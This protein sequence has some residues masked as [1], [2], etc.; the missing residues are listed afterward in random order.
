VRGARRTKMTM[1]NGA[2]YLQTITLP[3]N[4][5]ALWQVTYELVNQQNEA[6][7]SEEGSQNEASAEGEQGD[8]DSVSEAI[9]QASTHPSLAPYALF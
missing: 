8:Y 4:D 9:H 1:V 7:S 5:G 3:N 2:L 6:P